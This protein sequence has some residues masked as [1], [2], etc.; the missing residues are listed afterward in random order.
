[1]KKWYAVIGDPIKQSMSP[2]M[3]EAWFMKKVWMQP[4]FQSM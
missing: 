2:S 1:M 4:I 3:H